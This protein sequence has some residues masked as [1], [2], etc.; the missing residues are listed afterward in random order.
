MDLPSLEPYS[1]DGDSDDVSLIQP[2]TTAVGPK[3]WFKLVLLVNSIRLNAGIL[4]LY[5][6][7][8]FGE[9]LSFPL[10]QGVH[11]NIRALPNHGCVAKYPILSNAH[12]EEQLGMS[13]GIC[14]A[15]A[16]ELRVLSHEPIRHHPNVVD[17][18]GIGW[19]RAQSICVPVIYL[20]YATHGT[21]ADY[22]RSKDVCPCTKNA[23]AKDIVNGLQTLHECGITHGDLKL[24]N[25][26]IFKRSDGSVVA[27]LA[28]F[29]CAIVEAEEGTQLPGGTPPWNAP[30]WRENIEPS[31]MHK[32]DIYSLGLLIWRLTIN[33]K[34]PFENDEPQN[35]EKRKGADLMVEEAIQ[36]VEQHYDNI[37]LR[38]EVVMEKLRFELYLTCV[39]IPRKIFQ[40]SLR[41]SPLKRDLDDIAEALSGEESYR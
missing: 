21:L 10:S 37:L 19:A 14:N 5:L 13:S 25:V 16:L 33:G 35:I 9:L 1:S 15:V 22:L 17:I 7:R 34:N 39:A 18:V 28:D 20:E 2:A 30:E 31:L 11:F 36:S 40:H 8:D 24:E 4:N 27:K 12:N 32:T 29:G 26:L 38:D 3:N 23:L 41:F 6:I